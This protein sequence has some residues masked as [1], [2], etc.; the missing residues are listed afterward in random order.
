MAKK[1]LVTKG[2]MERFK[3]NIEFQRFLVDL[4][5]VTG[6]TGDKV[7]KVIGGTEDNITTLTSGGNIQDG[8]QSIDDLEARS[9]FLARIY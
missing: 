4:E 2:I 3:D 7:D 9:F 5:G 8:G 1:P 6:D